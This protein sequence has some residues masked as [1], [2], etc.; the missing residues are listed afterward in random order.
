MPWG[1]LNQLEAL[2]SIYMKF[3]VFISP[4]IRPTPLVPL[5]SWVTLGVQNYIGSYKNIME[6]WNMLTCN[7]CCLHCLVYLYSFTMWLV[8]FKFAISLFIIIIVVVV[9]II[10]I[11]IIIIIELK[12]DVGSGWQHVVSLHLLSISPLPSPTY[13]FRPQQCFFLDQF[14]RRDHISDPHV[15]FQPN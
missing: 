5:L 3:H 6:Y 1:S 14:N 4:K 2:K 15:V 13:P 11:V 9:V 10:I 8:N 12:N 7:V